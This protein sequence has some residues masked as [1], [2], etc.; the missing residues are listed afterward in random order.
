MGIGTRMPYLLKEID[1]IDSLVGKDRSYMVTYADISIPG[2][3]IPAALPKKLAPREA[4]EF[5]LFIGPKP[6]AGAG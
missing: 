3:P 2:K 1:S 4:A 5:K 6:L